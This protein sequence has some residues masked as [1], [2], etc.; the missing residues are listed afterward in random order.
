MRS[1]EREFPGEPSSA[2]A[3]RRFLAGLLTDWR[4]EPM[5]TSASL[6]LSELVANAVLH[7]R[8]PV[9][10]RIAVLDDALRLEVTDDSSRLPTRRTYSAQSTTGRGLALVERLGRRWGVEVGAV[11][12]TVWVELELSDHMAGDDTEEVELAILPHQGER[13]RPPS[14]HQRDDSSETSRIAFGWAA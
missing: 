3:A 10:V 14:R 5:E 1:A 4:C 13:V 8:S 2:G 11:G 6:L 9:R 7:A 12:K